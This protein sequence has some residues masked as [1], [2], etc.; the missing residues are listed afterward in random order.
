MQDIL[1]YILTLGFIVL[2]IFISYAAYQLTQ[3]LKSLKRLIDE[4]E[5]TTRDVNVIKDKIKL[6]ALTGIATILG[7]FVKKRR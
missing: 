5:D 6:R 2:V 3:T 7:M 1:Y 4:I